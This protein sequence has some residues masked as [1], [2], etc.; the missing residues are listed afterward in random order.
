[1]A[2]G[3]QPEEINVG[4][5]APRP[6]TDFK[7][8][9]RSVAVTAADAATYRSIAERGFPIRQRMMPTERAR[10]FLEVLAEKGL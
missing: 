5:Q 7:M 9:T 2:G 6:G 1:V 8:V 10:D 3:L 4:N